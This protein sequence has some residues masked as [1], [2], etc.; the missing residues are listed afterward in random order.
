[1][2]RKLELR[3]R[4]RGRLDPDRRGAHAADHLG[5]LRGEHRALRAHQSADPALKLHNPPPGKAN[6]EIESTQVELLGVKGKSL[7]TM[8]TGEALA[9]AKEGG[10]HVIEIDADAPSRAR[11]QLFVPGDY[12]IDEKAKQAHLTEEGH[13]NVEKLFA[14]RGDPRRGREP[15]RPRRTSG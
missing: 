11:A 6:D 15:L 3:D 8:S 14:A 1:M 4:R 2:Q 10:H 12:T 13:E 9:K 5:P 7:G